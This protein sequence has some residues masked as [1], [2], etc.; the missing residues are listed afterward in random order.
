MKIILADKIWMLEKIIFNNSDL[1]N[2]IIISMNPQCSYFLK[3]KNI[4]FLQTSDI[5]IHDDLWK[6]Y[7]DITDISFQI[8]KK[9]NQILFENDQRFKSLNWLI[10][11]DLHYSIK[12]CYDSFYYNTELVFKLIQKYNPS[13]FIISETKGIELNKFC[14]ISENSNLLGH[15]LSNHKD[16][17]KITKIKKDFNLN[18]SLKK[19]YNADKNMIYKIFN[20]LKKK[21]INLFNLLIF[22][23]KL[24]SKKYRYLSIGCYEVKSLKQL[25]PNLAKD[26]FVYYFEKKMI[27]EVENNNNQLLENFKRAIKEDPDFQKIL[28]YKNNKFD[29]I[30]DL[31]LFSIVNSLDYFLNE[32]YRAKKI[33]NKLNPKSVIF[34]SMV[35][36]YLPNV[37]FRKICKEL[38]IPFLTW[39]HGGYFTK[40]LG[41]YDVSDY[42]FCKS[43]ISYGQYLKDLID[44][45]KSTLELF[46]FK[47]NHK[48]YPVGSFRFSLDKKR[49]YHKKINLDFLDNSKKTI[50]FA[51]GCNIKNNQFY[52]GY[53][54]PKT[55]TSLWE[56]HFEILEI[57]SKYKDKYNIIF[58]DYPYGD[59]VLW[60]TIFKDLKFEQIT[61]ISDENSFSHLLR[62]SDLNIFPWMATTFFESLNFKSDIF[63]L[64]EDLF[65]DPFN[66]HLNDEIYWFNDFKKFKKNLD[67]YLEKG[68]F[69]NKIKK[70]SQN[71]FLNLNISEIERVKNLKKILENVT[72]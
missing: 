20:N 10:F 60:K 8:C 16:N 36:L 62:Y 72:S 32:Y 18:Y 9:L 70:K 39:V 56:Q 45:K 27:I 52:F 61:Y 12:I 41:G 42:R 48:I 2:F 22:N 30:L 11:D 65:T 34:Q 54:R 57:L 29:K 13:E 64:E 53:N 21:F 17:I 7:I 1:S 46:N 58:K 37:I 4:K 63:L 49:N 59:S 51:V 31:I 14:Q 23:L 68:K 33:V 50:L 38:N 55:E 47:E 24:L 25:Y 3:K 6:K 44:S 5:C 40:S 28:I 43:H 71:Y 66:K 67:L 69:F 26:F 15:I 35:P 19:T